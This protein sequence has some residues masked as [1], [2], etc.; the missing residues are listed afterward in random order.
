MSKFFKR[1]WFLIGLLGVFVLTL[2]DFSGSISGTGR[3]LKN[4][5]GPETVII[6]IFFL[7]G[8]LLDAYQIK[9]GLSEFTGTLLALLIIFVVAPMVAALMA[10]LP[11]NHGLT[12][13]LIIVA[14]M[15]TTLS[16]GVVMTAAAGG[17]MAQA[18]F[19]TIL[20]NALAI[21]T[22]PVTLAVLVHGI[23]PTTAVDI[24]AG[25]IM[26]TLGCYV[27]LPLFSGMSVKRFAGNGLNRFV[28]KVQI[29]NQCLVLAM[30]WMG[31]SQTR[32]VIMDG[33]RLMIQIVVLSFVFHALIL[34]AAFLLTRSFGLGK[35]RRES[36]IFMG[37]QKTLPLSIIIQVTLF[38]QYGLALV[39]CV[40]HHVV[41]LMMDSYL[42]G[43][44]RKK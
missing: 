22:I 29:F 42:V 4:H 43:R 38:P 33:G 41:H 30:I 15:P 1:Y 13:G 26:F 25:R 9:G 32:P 21:V 31:I 17:N 27:I 16:S 5:Y 19:I 14:V 36:V 11:L 39:F 24:D 18:L 10:Y 8:L 40:I 28:P 12:I 6:I 34:A 35:G 20:S 2:A 3:W 23:A 44:L 7:S 37:G